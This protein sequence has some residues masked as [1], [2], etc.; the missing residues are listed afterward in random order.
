MKKIIIISI[1]LAGL[2]SCSIK[3]NSFKSQVNG[4]IKTT[5]KDSITSYIN[6]L[7]SSC[8]SLTDNKKECIIRK[9][10]EGDEVCIEKIKYEMPYYMS[11]NSTDPR[12]N[13]FRK[14]RGKSLFNQIL[15][16]GNDFSCSTD[17]DGYNSGSNGH[18]F[19]SH[20]YYEMIKS[21]DGITVEEYLEQ[22]VP[23]ND[24][25]FSQQQKDKCDETR[26]RKKYNAIKSAYAEGKIVLKDYG[27]E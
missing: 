12:D 22:V 5:E 24:D 20:F 19:Y 4:E 23:Y 7:K 6:S 17:A 9:A 11:R 8:D 25:A 16:I 21:I 15:K 18:L 10:F 13:I 2:Y 27:E 1:V 14:F 3:R 26:S